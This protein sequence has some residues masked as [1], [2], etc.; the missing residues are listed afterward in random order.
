MSDEFN[1]LLKKAYH[2]FQGRD[3]IPLEMIKEY[4]E[5]EGIDVN[6]E[7]SNKGG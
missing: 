1:T 6:E 2:S 4:L 7:Y 3:D 5:I